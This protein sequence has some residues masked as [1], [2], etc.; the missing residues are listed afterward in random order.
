MCQAPR[1]PSEDLQQRSEAF[2]R[3]I[4]HRDVTAADEILDADYALVLVHPAPAV[5]PKARWIATLPDYIVHEYEVLDVVS[6]IDGDCATILQRVRQRATVLGVD[7]SGVFVLSDIWRDRDDRWRI[8]R[9]HSTPLD[10]GEMP[11]Q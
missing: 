9:R 11:R 3:C 10:A 1:V 8:W 2:Q 5:M 4:Q 6:D 7:R